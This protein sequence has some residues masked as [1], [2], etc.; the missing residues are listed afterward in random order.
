MLDAIQ[1]LPVVGF[2]REARGCRSRGWR[3]TT[4]FDA[5][6]GLPCIVTDRINGRRSGESQS[7]QLVSV[8]GPAT[9]LR[10]SKPKS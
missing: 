5:P 4:P 8:T 9:G 1:N 2:V 7:G 3:F 6:R 10:I